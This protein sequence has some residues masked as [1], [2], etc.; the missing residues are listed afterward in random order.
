MVIGPAART[1]ETLDI[2]TGYESTAHAH[3]VSFYAS[4]GL[5]RDRF[6]LGDE[7]P[8]L[9][10]AALE[11]LAGSPSMRVLEVGYQAGGFA[12]P[13]L[14]ALHTEPGFHYTGLDSLVYQNAVPPGLLAEYLLERDVARDRFELVT[15]DAWDFLMTTSERFDLVLVDHVKGLYRRDLETIL[16]RGLVAGGGV[17]LLHDVLAKAAAAWV[18]CVKVAERYGCSWEIRADVPA[19]LA[20]VRT[21]PRRRRL[22]AMAA[23][24]R[25]SAR[26]AVRRI[27]RALRSRFQWRD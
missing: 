4:R 3:L 21:P 12:A 11:L 27:N 17:I 7:H 22:R 19:G 9:E 10:R 26:Y 5:G 2:A 16:A 24:A 8:A 14:E 6:W 18:D 23:S 25:L 15:S 1:H 13:V 20:I